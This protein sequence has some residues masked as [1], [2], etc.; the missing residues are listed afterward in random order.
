MLK[1]KLFF[2]K[3]TA[4]VTGSTRGIGRSIADL[5]VSQGCDVIYTGTSS[6]IN[7]NGSHH[8]Y[9]QLDLTN[10][11]SIKCFLLEIDKIEKID[12]LIN[13]AGINYIEPI[14]QINEEHWKKIIEINLTGAMLLT[15]EISKKMKETRIRGKILNI[16]SIF[17]VVS[18]AKRAAYSASKSGLIGLT[19]ATA[20]D[21]AP[22]NILVNA[23]CPGFTIT[24]LTTAILSKNE[25]KELTSEIPLGRFAQVDE[26]A[27]A[28][29]FLC[30]DMNTFMTGQE[31][32]IDGGFIIR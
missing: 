16:S 24:E 14:D 9:L 7:L 11:Y 5:L 31:L 29:V 17:G 10:D 8:I 4:I 32:I 13:N 19:R 15:R 25:I 27:K 1:S 30:S 21:L 3:K 22:Y 26:I 12:I 2:K 18:K 20:L 23:L 6:N 28:A